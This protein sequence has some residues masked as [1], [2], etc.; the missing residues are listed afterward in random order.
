MVEISDIVQVVPIASEPDRVIWTANPTGKYTISSAYEALRVKTPTVQW[1]RLVW[2]KGPSPHHSFICWLAIL[3]RLAVKARIIR[4]GLCD[5]NICPC[6]GLSAE[7]MEHLLF[8]CSFP[9]MVWNGVMRYAGVV[10]PPKPWRWELVWWCRKAG[11][12]SQL[13]V[14]RRHIFCATIYYI[15]KERNDSVFGN[16]QVNVQRVINNI[17]ESFF[18]YSSYFTNRNFVRLIDQ[19]TV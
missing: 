7:T 3:N 16:Q 6:C 17:R 19:W 8:D 10:R 13:A 11:G 5:D 14:L 9:S 15:W 18:C 1:A 4:W 12:K 2:G